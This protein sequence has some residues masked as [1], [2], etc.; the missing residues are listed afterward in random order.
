MVAVGGRAADELLLA[1][2][3]GMT[4]AEVA[5]ALDEATS[6]NLLVAS[7]DGTAD[8]YAFRH[9]LLR[10]ALY[11]D[12]LPGA[13]RRLHAR[14]AEVLGERPRLDGAAGA[15]Q[16]AEIAGHASAAHDLPLALRRW[17]EAGRAS[18]AAFAS[19]SASGAYERALELWDVVPEADRP[20]GLEYVELLEDAARSI[21]AGGE[22]TRS[23]EVS[24]LA[25]EQ[26]DARADP[27]RRARLLEMLARS[28]YLMT[29]LG[30]AIALLEEAAAARWR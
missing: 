13:R 19:V 11:D 24:R 8:G 22:V 20:E 2:V 7:D 3:S 26:L 30:G 28:R 4:E 25:L 14:Y 15:A 1:R 6:Q 12:L 29:D 9:A 17:I 10:E 23:G 27:A 16:L 18:D 21:L 5:T